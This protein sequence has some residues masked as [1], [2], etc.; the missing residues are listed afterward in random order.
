MLSNANR[1][2]A[3]AGSR[4]KAKRANGSKPSSFGGL[5]LFARSGCGSGP[6]WSNTMPRWRQSIH[7]AHGFVPG[8]AANNR[9]QAMPGIMG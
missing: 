5:Q 8:A 4:S 3:L 6:S 7:A 9:R 2:Y 1:T